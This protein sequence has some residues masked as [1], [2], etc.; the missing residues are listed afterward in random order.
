[1]ID[2]S[3]IFNLCGTDGVPDVATSMANQ[4]ILSDLSVPIFEGVY[5][6]IIPNGDLSFLCSTLQEASLLQHL[7]RSCGTVGIAINV[8]DMDILTLIGCVCTFT[9]RTGANVFFKNNIPDLVNLTEDIVEE[10]A[11][12]ANLPFDPMI[13]M[14]GKEYLLELASNAIN[15]IFEKLVDIL[16]RDFA[17]KGVNIHHWEEL[18]D[19]HNELMQT[20]ELRWMQRI[21]AGYRLPTV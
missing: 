1:M 21:R 5:L 15:I 14:Q 10:L 7:G 2:V 12:L 9:P 19:F 11:S 18:D 3:D 17:N 4:N 13:C 6:K 16:E 20:G 8:L